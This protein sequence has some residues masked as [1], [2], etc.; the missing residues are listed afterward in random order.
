[1]S[2]TSCVTY[3]QVSYALWPWVLYL[4]VLIYFTGL[5]WGSVIFIFVITCQHVNRHISFIKKILFLDDMSYSC[6]LVF[7]LFTVIYLERVVY[8]GVYILGVFS[9]FPFIIFSFIIFNIF[10]DNTKDYVYLE[11]ITLRGRPVNPSSNSRTRII[12]CKLHVI[13]SFSPSHLLPPL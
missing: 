4:K 6:C 12:A 10:F 13:M 11:S 2:L 7:L 5:F 1:M 9:L 3:F 8:S